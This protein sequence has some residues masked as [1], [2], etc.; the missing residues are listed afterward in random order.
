M[1]DGRLATIDETPAPD[2]NI[3]P[4]PAESHNGL[5]QGRLVNVP[6]HDGPMWRLHS[7]R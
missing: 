5:A 7:C 2:G 3:I 4:W 6:V 1:T